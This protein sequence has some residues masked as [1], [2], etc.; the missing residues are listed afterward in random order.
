MSRKV[1]ENFTSEGGSVPLSSYG[2]LT[3]AAQRR[4]SA[5]AKALQRGTSKVVMRQTADTLDEG[6][7]AED[8]SKKIAIVS[9]FR[10]GAS[11]FRHQE[12]SLEQCNGAS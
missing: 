2:F 12:N 3:E 9:N 1:P 4:V 6:L 11:C 10:F 7:F 5:F 8:S